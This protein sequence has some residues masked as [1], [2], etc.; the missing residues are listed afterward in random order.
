MLWLNIEGIWNN[1]TDKN[2]QFL[3][4]LIQQ[5]NSS[6]V[7][8]GI[9][10]SRYHWT[11]IMNNVTKFSSD[12]PLWYVHHDNDQSFEDFRA[13]GGWKRPSMKQ[14]IRDVKKCGVVFDKNF[15]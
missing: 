13:F 11:S 5:I 2:I 3:D 8:F 1:N 6:A 15:A 4:E 14:F 12:S 9:N 10:T 7:R